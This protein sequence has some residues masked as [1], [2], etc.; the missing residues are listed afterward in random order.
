MSRHVVWELRTWPKIRQQ[1]K[2]VNRPVVGKNV[3]CSWH[4]REVRKEWK[5]QVEWGMGRGRAKF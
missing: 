3:C 5:E 4:K 1:S 2:I